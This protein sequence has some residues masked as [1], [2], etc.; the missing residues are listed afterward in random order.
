MDSYVRSVNSIH[1]DASAKTGKNVKEI[2]ETLAKS[3]FFPII[4]LEIL[5]Q[6]ENESSNKFSRKSSKKKVGSGPDFNP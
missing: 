3:N 5:I 6:I 2:F 4:R 1:F